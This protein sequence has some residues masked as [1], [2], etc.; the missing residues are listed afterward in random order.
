MSTV[1]YYTFGICFLLGLPLFWF[2]LLGTNFEKLF[3]QGRVVVI[4]IGYAL[5]TIILSGLFSLSIALFASIF[6]NI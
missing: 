1:F 5:A 3:K 6:T 4:R 2:I